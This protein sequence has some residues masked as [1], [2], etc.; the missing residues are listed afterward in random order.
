MK[1]Q[2]Y[3]PSGS[4]I[5]ASSCEFGCCVIIVDPVDIASR[6]GSIGVVVQVV[7]NG[8]HHVACLVGRWV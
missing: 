2:M 8:F 1:V 5:I 4:W 6:S 3:L 7:Y